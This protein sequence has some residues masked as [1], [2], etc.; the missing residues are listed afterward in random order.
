MERQVILDRDDPPLL[1]VVLDEAALRRQIGTG[2]VMHGQLVH[3]AE[4]SGRPNITVQVI[5]VGAGGHSGLLGAFVI[6][7]LASSTSIVYLETV[8]GG[9]IAEEP[10]VVADVALTFDTLRSEALPRTAS[11]DLVMKV[12]E[13]QWT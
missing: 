4:M 13:E 9:Q 1:W 8:A 6:A 2:K 12:A 3:L 5:P 10:S 11:R 7:E